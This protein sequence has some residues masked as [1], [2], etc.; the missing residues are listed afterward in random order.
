MDELIARIRQTAREDSDT[1]W[2][3]VATPEQ[4]SYFEDVLDVELPALL[5]RCYTEIS[6]GGFGP[7][8][9]VAGLP[10]GHETAWGDLIESVKELRLHEDCDDSLLPLIDW[11]CNEVTCVDSD[12]GLVVTFLEGDFHQED[13]TF[14]T[15]MERWCQ[16]EMPDLR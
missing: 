15:L 10:G 11:G 14:E 4:I 9:G 2:F 1:K 7:G 5:K 6:S 8:Y 13:Y 3:D 16:G 12:D